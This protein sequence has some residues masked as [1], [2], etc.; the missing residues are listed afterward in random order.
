MQLNYDLELQPALVGMLAD[1]SAKI[2]DSY[3]VECGEKEVVRPGTPVVGG[4]DAR[5]VKCCDDCAKVFGIVMHTHKE[6]RPNAKYYPEGYVVPV[7]TFGRVWVAVDGDVTAH[8]VAKYDVDQ[9]VW[10]ATNGTEVP[11]V[12]FVSAAQGG[13]AVVEIR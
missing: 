12:K 3:H 10:S 11:N 1:T 4:T 8:T 2:T 9:K 13:M 7:V 5:Q 6:V